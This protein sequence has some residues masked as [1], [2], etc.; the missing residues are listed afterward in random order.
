MIFRDLQSCI[1]L[2]DLQNSLSTKSPS[3]VLAFSVVYTG[4]VI[5]SRN[6]LQSSYAFVLLDL[7]KNL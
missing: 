2:H 7:K 5:L 3:Q 1:E 4:I 6:L